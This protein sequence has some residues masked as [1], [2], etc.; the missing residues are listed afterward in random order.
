MSRRKGTSRW[1]RWVARAR[2]AR[3]WP[4]L[5]LVLVAPM[6]WAGPYIWDQDGDHVFV[7]VKKTI[8][9]NIVAPD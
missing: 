1:T 9:G 8:W 7:P 2:W 5:T 3:A 4:L 6:A